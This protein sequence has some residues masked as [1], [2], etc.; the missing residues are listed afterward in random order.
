MTE[1]YNCL[2]IKFI[3]KVMGKNNLTSGEYPI[4]L[5]QLIILEKEITSPETL[6]CKKIVKGTE[7][8]LDIC[9]SEIGGVSVVMESSIPLTDKG[10][11][12]GTINPQKVS[13]DLKYYINI[14]NKEESGRSYFYI[15]IYK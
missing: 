3:E 7:K 4:T 8:F 1:N 11:T 9:F 10:D 13:E 6:N 15:S 2:P 14:S 5:E 12:F